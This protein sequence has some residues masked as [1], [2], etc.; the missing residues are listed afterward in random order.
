MKRN[1]KIMCAKAW[2]LV[3]AAAMIISTITVVQTG[4][5]KANTVSL[6]KKKYHLLL[7]RRKKLQ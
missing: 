1:G 2:S 5:A 3:L 6:S 4:E 7:V